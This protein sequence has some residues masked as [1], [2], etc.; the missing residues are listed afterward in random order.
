VISRPLGF[1]GG[2]VAVLASLDVDLR[3]L[4]RAAEAPRGGKTGEAARGPVRNAPDCREITDLSRY[5][6]DREPNRR[7]RK[8]LSISSNGPAPATGSLWANA[9][10]PSSFPSRGRGRARASNC[11]IAQALELDR[12]DSLVRIGPGSVAAAETIV[13]TAAVVRGKLEGMDQHDGTV[14]ATGP[15]GACGLCREQHA[16]QDSHLF[17]AALY[18][19]LRDPDRPNPNPVMVT[20]DHAGTTSRQIS[21]YFLCWDCEQRFSRRGEQYVLNQCARRDRFPLRELLLSS[22]PSEVGDPKTAVYDVGD[23]LG[24]HVQEYLYFAASIFWRAAARSWGEQM[25]QFS[26]GTTYQEQF[27][28]YLLGESGWPQN[29]RLM[30]HVSSGELLDII[31]DP[32]GVRIGAVH[33]YKFCIPG[34]LFILFVGATVPRDHDHGM[35]NSTTGRFMGLLP[36]ERDSLFEG[37]GGLAREALRNPRSLR[38]AR[39]SPIRPTSALGVRAR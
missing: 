34:I 17:P 24:E 8:R 33:R 2:S 38:P 31:T 32:V 5:I 14:G 21:A 13:S 39:V 1:C 30:I 26:L 4:R 19:I 18:K 25:R 35:L 15:V 9:R 12:P 7:R 36:F 16:L 20:R 11:G 22:N 3:S 23:L 37:F 27:R 10:P 29:A 6:A 28:S